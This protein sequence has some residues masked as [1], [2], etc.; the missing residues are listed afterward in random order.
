MREA[1]DATVSAGKST[2]LERLTVDAKKQYGEFWPVSVVHPNGRRWECCGALRRAGED[3]AQECC[4][5]CV[6]WNAE[7]KAAVHGKDT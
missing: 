6:S 3:T 2:R 7:W 1:Q 4:P 5:A